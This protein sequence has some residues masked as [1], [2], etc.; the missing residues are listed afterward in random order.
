MKNLIAVSRP[1]NLLV[2]ALTQFVLYY[3]FLLEPTS[4]LEIEGPIF[5]NF[6]LA[7]LI[8]ATCIICLNGY[9]I[10]DYFDF[11]ADAQ[12]KSKFQFKYKNVYL[13]YYL[14]CYFIGFILSVYLANYLGKIE[15]SLLYILASGGLYLYSSFLKAKFIWGNILVALYTAMTIMIIYLAE[16]EFVARV[17]YSNPFLHEEI[18]FTYLFLAVMAFLIN[19]IR[20]IVKD[21]EDRRGDAQSGSQAY[22][23]TKPISKVKLTLYSLWTLLFVTETMWLAYIR[24]QID[25]ITGI[26]VF[27]LLLSP[28]FY[29]FYRISESAEVKDFKFLSLYCKLM[30][31]ATLLHLILIKCI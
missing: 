4:H 20:E 16:Y 23:V 7:L 28:L 9:L 31:F 2:V 30:I 3:F 21:L 10:N 8:L 24:V 5:N 18:I 1:I 13:K 19:L 12:Y 14:L 27:I 15:W 29:L 11:D 26:Q 6:R 25:M 17:K 22:A